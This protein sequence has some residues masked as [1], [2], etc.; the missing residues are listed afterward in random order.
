[1]SLVTAQ[2]HALGSTIEGGFRADPEAG[3]QLWTRVRENITAFE[4]RF[5]RFLPA[6]ELSQLNSHAGQPMTVSP[7][8]IALLQE[9]EKQWKDTNGLFDPTI[10]YALIK[11]G[12]DRSFELLSKVTS[13]TIGS[14]SKLVRAKFSNIAVDTQRSTVSLPLGVSLDFGGIGKGYLLDQ[15]VPLIEEV[16]TDYWL[17]FG[18]D[19]VLSGH[20][21]GQRHW[22]IGVQDPNDHTRDV[23]K[24]SL[25]EGRW[26]VATSGTT[27]RKGV[28]NGN[29]WHHLI[30]PRTGRSAVTDV[31]GATVLAPNATIADVY[32]K[33]VL[34]QGSKDGIAWVTQHP[35]VEAL[36]ITVDRLMVTTPG[37]QSRITLK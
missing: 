6:S 25:P 11:A 19:L 32:A 2:F 13:A 10:G 23:A 3:Q 26:G 18:G 8:M 14:K 16:T 5:S 30:D 9:I 33:T 7:E 12:Y 24:L 4:N 22:V 36:A 27:K 21:E 31:V 15:L 20:D 37:M 28:H 29:P 17:S 1:M 34:L 35:N